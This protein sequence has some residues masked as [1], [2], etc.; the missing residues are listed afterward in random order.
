MLLDKNMKTAIK[1][2]QNLKRALLPNSVE[3]V[4]RG[5]FHTSKLK[6]IVFSA[7]TTEIGADAFLQ[8]QNLRYVKLPNK[9]VRIGEN[10]FSGCSLVS[11]TFPEGLEIIEQASLMNNRI[12]E[13]HIPASV[14]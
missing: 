7:N 8:C 10:A 12:K 11:I 5:C 13:V 14:Y 3:S 4:G 1:C 9:L 2:V 6:D